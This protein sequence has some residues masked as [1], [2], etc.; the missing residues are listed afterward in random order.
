[1]KLSVSYNFFNGEEHLEKSILSIRNVVDHISIVFQK[2]SNSGETVSSSALDALERIRKQKLVDV[3]YEYE[4]NLQLRRPENEIQKRKIGLKLAR[5]ARSSHFFTMDADE[6]Y[7]EKELSNAKDV[8]LKNKITSSSVGS[9]FHLKRP[10]W[11]SKDTTNCA[12]ISKVGWLTKIADLPYPVEMIDPTRKIH[13]WPLRHHHFD[14]T[15]VAMYHMNFVRQDISN[16]LRNSST[17][18]QAF[19]DKVGDSIQNWTEG[20]PFIFPNKG[21]FELQNVP[22]EFDTFD[23]N[24]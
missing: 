14:E 20:T 5:R 11:R 17:T 4:P 7:R 6:F 15:D 13:V 18:D 10:I 21:T 3:I 19:L 8:I 1:M 24:K 9:F 2:V 22:N 16:K 12:F 23:P